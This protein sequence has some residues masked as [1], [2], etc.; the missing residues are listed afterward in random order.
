MLEIGIN[1]TGSRQHVRAR[2][3]IKFIHMNDVCKRKCCRDT[4]SRDGECRE[5]Y[6]ANPWKLAGITECVK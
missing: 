4:K 1:A 6:D 3:V 5:L 2:A